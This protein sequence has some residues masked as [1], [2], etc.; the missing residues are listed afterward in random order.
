MSNNYEAFNITDLFFEAAK[1]HPLKTAIIAQGKRIHF[2]GLAAEV[3]RTAQYFLKKGIGKGDRVLV[4]VPMGVNLYRIVLALFKIGATAVFLDEWVSKQRME[5]CCKV[6]Q[7]KAFIGIAKARILA[8]LSAELRK[9]PIK[10]GVGYKEAGPKMPIPVTT[11]E[12]T[13]LITFTTGS[14]GTPKAALRTHGFLYHQFIA[15]REEIKPADANV[16]MVVLPIVLLINLATGTTSVITDFKSSKPNSLKPEQIIKD[17]ETYSVNL[18]I[19]SPFFVKKLSEYIIQNQISIAGMEKIFTGGAPVFPAEA[20]IY[21]EAFP[22]T[23]IQIVYGSTEAE[24]I[25]LINI[26]RLLTL[27]DQIFNGLN[28]GRVAECA[29]VKIIQILDKVIELNTEGELTGITLPVSQVGEI[30]VSGKHVLKQ[31]FN[32]D[33]ALKRNKIFIADECWHRTGDSGYLNAAGDLFLTGRCNT[34]I[35]KDGKMVYPFIYENYFQSVD[36][37]E[38][39]TMVLLKDRITAV[40]ELKN[41]RKDKDVKNTLMADDQI[42]Q[43]V[44]LEKAPRDL[45]HNSKIDYQNLATVLE[46]LD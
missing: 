15:L 40:I 9:I 3:E 18:I 6:A 24:P 33:K 25:S 23:T 44:F 45:R 32:N 42:E 37:V 10:L 39:G 14:T 13:A 41:R 35:E 20:A 7:C 43:V 1:K 2:G 27:N 21:N 22:K 11:T 4:F 16:A 26:R 29:Q 17:I 8:F 12:D 5:E 28:V 46:K 19:A 31:Y 30:I 36:G 34:L 38:V